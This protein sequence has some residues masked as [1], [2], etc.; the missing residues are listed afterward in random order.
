MTPELSKETIKYL[1]I[2][3]NEHGPSAYVQLV[4]TQK[5]VQLQFIDSKSK[6]TRLFTESNKA[7]KE[8]KV[9]DV[10]RT[11]SNRNG[12]HS[13]ALENPKRTRVHILRNK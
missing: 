6:I 2:G 4:K 10:H 7:L 12:D 8:W 11:N 9:K 5:G 13:N 1:N 3:K